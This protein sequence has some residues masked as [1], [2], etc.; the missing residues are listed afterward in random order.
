M[1]NARGFPLES[2][3][4]MWAGH[5]EVCIT[6]PYHNL[7]YTLVPWGMG[8]YTGESMYIHAHS[9]RNSFLG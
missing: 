2:P 1:T 3:I 6:L 7:H 4:T 8:G 9:Y 5:G